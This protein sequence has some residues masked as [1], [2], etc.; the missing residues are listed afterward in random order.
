MA[1]RA[2]VE[3]TRGHP[4]AHLVAA[5]VRPP[6]SPHHLARLQNL[7]DDLIA[8]LPPASE[9]ATAIVRRAGVAQIHCGFA[10]KNDAD[11]FA[12]LAGAGAARQ[13][14]NWASRRCFTLDAST[15]LVLR[16]DPAVPDR[17]TGQP[18]TA[19]AAR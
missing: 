17:A 10:D 11:R 1:R 16:D 13:L 15:E 9:Y 5:V 2:W 18:A 6:R 12:R 19:A 7:L 8:S 3:F 4:N 14:G